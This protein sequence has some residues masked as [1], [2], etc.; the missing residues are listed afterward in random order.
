MHIGFN[1]PTLT[2]NESKYVLE[3]MSSSKLSGDGIFNARCQS[4]FEKELNCDK[5]LL[6][7]SCT[8]ALEMAAILVNIQPRDEVIMPS[9]TFVSTANAFVMRGA[10][11]IRR[12]TTRY[13]EYRRITNRASN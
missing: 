9:F 2:G 13:Y 3:A 11:I 8:Q 10:K 4:W 5:A 12:Y 1:K 7:P 6:T